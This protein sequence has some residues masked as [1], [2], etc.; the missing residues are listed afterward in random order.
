M[1][2]EKAAALRKENARGHRQKAGAQVD[3]PSQFLS[4][5]DH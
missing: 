3:A 5:A 1:I 2:I 4:V